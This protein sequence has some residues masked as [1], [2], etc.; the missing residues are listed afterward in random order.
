M[1]R[2]INQAFLM[3]PWAMREEVLNI[4]TEIVMRH[5]SGEKLS[6]DEIES[7][8]GGG[9]KKEADYEVTPG[10]VAR[11]PI[12]G[13]IAKRASLV[14]GISQPRGT[15]VEEIKKDVESAMTDDKVTSIAFDIDSPGGSVDGVP[16]LADYILSVR[17][18]KPMVAYVDG[19]MASAAYWLG[20]CADRIYATRSSEVGSIGVYA[21][22]HD[23]HRALKNDGI[24]SKIFKAGKYKAAGHP[25]KPMT[26]EE[27]QLIQGQ[28]DEYYG[29][30]IDAVSKNRRISH[31]AAMALGDGRIHIGQKALA[32]GLIDGISDIDTYIQYCDKDSN[33]TK[34]MAASDAIVNCAACKHEFHLIEQPEA[35][36]GAVK[37][38]GCGVTCSHD[39]AVLV[40]GNVTKTKE[41]TMELK[42]VT[43]DALKQ[44]RPDIMVAIESPVKAAGD[45]A[46][47]EAVKA[48]RA[49][50]QDIVTKAE[51]YKDVDVSALVK[52]SI[53]KGEDIV[54]AESAFKSKKLAALQGAAPA[55]PG[56]NTDEPVK[57]KSHLEVAKEYA[58]EHKCSMTVALKAT[59]PVRKK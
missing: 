56:A 50:C 28:V 51:E 25:M 5:I 54:V 29:M 48:E 52:T 42:D 33:K 26:E 18:K 31:D 13:I 12:Y 3:R 49:R 24:D 47:A 20:S 41:G 9:N 55:M 15:S 35:A 17:N 11:I 19:M 59:A 6:K 1:A 23:M 8:T 14:N 57:T 27:E 32:A 44:G 46:K 22:V 58:A 16:E 43:V 45:A 38:P 21:V 37:C 10:G 53:E 39:G 30:F 2:R 40:D 7:R 36:S 4:M 34:R